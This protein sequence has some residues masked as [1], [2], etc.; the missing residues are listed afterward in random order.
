MTS[1]KGKWRH[2]GG[3]K[4]VMLAITRNVFF[5]SSLVVLTIESDAQIVFLTSTIRSRNKT[6]SSEYN[7]EKEMCKTVWRSGTMKT[8]LLKIIF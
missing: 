6:K 2:L 5:V 8:K 1:V 4:T 3:V 7:R